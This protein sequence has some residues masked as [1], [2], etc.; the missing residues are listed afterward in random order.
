MKRFF[1]NLWWRWQLKKYQ[2]LARNQRE[3]FEDL[4]KK[5]NAAM[6]AYWQANDNID[7]EKAFVEFPVG[8]RRPE[9]PRDVEVMDHFNQPVKVKEMWY[10]D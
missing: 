6:Q 8:L 9:P 10:K 4:N 5:L 1:K 3:Y 7:V 2:K